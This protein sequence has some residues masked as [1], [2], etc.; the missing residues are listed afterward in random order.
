MIIKREV[1]SSSDFPSVYWATIEI[2]PEEARQYIALI[3]TCAKIETPRGRPNQVSWFDY[4]PDWYADEECER[5]E[6]PDNR[7]IAA[8]CMLHVMG[9]CI[10]WS[11]YE[12]HCDIEYETAAIYRSALVKISHGYNPDE[13][14]MAVCPSCGIKTI[15]DR[16]GLT[17]EEMMCERCYK[18]QNPEEASDE[19]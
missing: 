1:N 5:P 13:E 4:S 2:T 18:E 16:E 12:K 17:E 7:F 9:D 15:P 6:D 8:G 3:D 10:Y 19:P 14:D 11:C